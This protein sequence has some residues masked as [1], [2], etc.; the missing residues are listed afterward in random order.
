MLRPRNK[1]DVGLKLLRM[2]CALNS[3]SL[4]FKTSR[5]IINYKVNFVII[6]RVIWIFCRNNIQPEE[7][8]LTDHLMV[9]QTVDRGINCSH[10][11]KFMKGLFYQGYKCVRCESQVHREC[12]TKLRK[13]GTVQAQPP[14]LPPRPLL[15]LPIPSM[16]ESNATVICVV[17]VTPIIFILSSI[18]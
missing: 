17:I 2:H 8:R 7:S 18:Y 11:K 10:C 3:N 13:C 4:T 16:Q 1:R 9:M 5:K 15:L 6:L 12:I 14:E